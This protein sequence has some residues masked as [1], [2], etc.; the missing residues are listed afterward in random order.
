MP[1]IRGYSLFHAAF[2]RKL[3]NFQTDSARGLAVDRSGG[4]SCHRYGHIAQ[5]TMFCSKGVK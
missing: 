1:V 5:T 2:Y 3:T 4:F